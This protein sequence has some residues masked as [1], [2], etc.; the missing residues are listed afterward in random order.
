MRK[1]KALVVSV[2]FVL[3]MTTS[4][5][6]LAKPKAG[7]ARCCKM[8]HCCYGSMKC[9]KK[10]NHSCCTGHKQGGECCCKKGSCPMPTT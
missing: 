1:A 4:S 7:Y 2:L 3:A 10:A 9:C 8:R 6:V 5:T